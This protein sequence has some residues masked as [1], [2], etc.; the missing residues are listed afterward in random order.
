MKFYFLI[1]G[2]MDATTGLLLIFLPGVA[3]SLMGLQPPIDLV[4]LRWIGVF[5]FSVG[6][7]YLLPFLEASDRGRHV[8]QGLA[9]KATT[10]TRGCVAV[11]VTTQIIMSQLE[12]AWLSVAGV[13]GACALIQIYIW[14]RFFRNANPT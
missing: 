8:Q 12:I 7:F 10:L 13:D 5:V 3:L 4:L 9:L 14:W 11:F 2:A 6:C 1:V